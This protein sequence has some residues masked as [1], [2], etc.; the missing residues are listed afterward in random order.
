MAVVL[1]SMLVLA[2]IGD[3]AF[4]AILKLYEIGSETKVAS[5]SVLF[6]ICFYVKVTKDRW[7][8]KMLLKLTES[9]GMC[10]APGKGN[11]ILYQ[12][13]QRFCDFG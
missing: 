1:T 7:V 5:M 13:L 6:R 8:L 10:R 12:F 2:S 11:I 3:S 9:V 4:D